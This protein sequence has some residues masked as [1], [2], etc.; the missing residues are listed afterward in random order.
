MYKQLHTREAEPPVHVS[1][2]DQDTL[3]SDQPPADPFVLLLPATI[4]GYGLHDKK[5]SE[6]EFCFAFARRVAKI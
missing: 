4:R 3:K 2:L 5:W 1:D 6:F